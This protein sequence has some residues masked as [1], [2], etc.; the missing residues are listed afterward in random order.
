VGERREEKTNDKA[1]DADG[2]REKEKREL[3]NEKRKK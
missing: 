1:E 3:N 2:R